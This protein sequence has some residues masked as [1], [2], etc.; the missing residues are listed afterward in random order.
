MTAPVLVLGLGNSLCGDD[1]FGVAAV[2]A[3][4]RRGGMAPH[5][6]VMDGGTQGIYLLPHV[7]AAAR[8]LV[9]DA[10]NTGAAPGELVVLENDAV[11]RFVA[12]GRLSAHA[13]GL[14][15]LLA[16]AQLGGWR[17]RALALVGAQVE[18][19]GLGDAMSPAVAGLVAPAVDRAL[20]ILAGWE[21][22]A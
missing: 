15:E 5:V 16:L 6:T 3:L 19:M 14:G 2:E 18:R 22:A 12:A 4:E 13:G 11:P 7:K 9:F 20:D 1:A 21:E 17:P 10:V 8:L